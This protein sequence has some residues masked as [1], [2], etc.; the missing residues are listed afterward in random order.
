MSWKAEARRLIN[1]SLEPTGFTL[2]R[3]L[4]EMAARSMESTS[5]RQRQI[6]AFRQELAQSLVDFPELDVGILQE[7]DIAAFAAELPRCPVHQDTG[8]GGFSAAMLLWVIGR[9][10]KPELVVESG[11]FRG[12]TTWVFRQASPQARQ[13]AFDISFAERQRVET[14]VEYHEHDW[15]SVPLQAPGGASALIY[16]DD[17]VDQWRRIR[18]A[19]A[20]GFRYL[21]FDDSLP[22]TALH[23]D[24]WAAAP[25]MDMLFESDIADGEEIRWRT[26]C[27]PFTHRYDAA[28]AT[29]TRALVRHH[30]RLPDLR[31]V[32]GYAPANLVLVALR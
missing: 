1:R 27:G 25:T 10:L 19:A 13:Y 29:E 21:V 7:T 17:H 5:V 15:M 6:A 2:R 4:P 3:F 20:R 11:V 22:S 12:F 31:F 24:G 18:E 30:V 8:G 14:G 9:M 23:N 26:E 28:Q 16:F 32:F